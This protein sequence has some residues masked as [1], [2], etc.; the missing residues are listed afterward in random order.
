ML[1]S[2]KYQKKKQFLFSY[3][4]FAYFGYGVQKYL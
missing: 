4:L 1:N 3:L 2:L